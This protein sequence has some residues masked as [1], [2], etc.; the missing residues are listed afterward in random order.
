[1]LLHHSLMQP[2]WKK[3]WLQIGWSWSSWSMTSITLSHCALCVWKMC[4]MCKLCKICKC[5]NCANCAKCANVQTVHFEC[6]PEM[7]VNF[8]QA[9]Q[10]NE[11]QASTIAVQLQ[12]CN[13]EYHWV[14]WCSASL[15]SITIENCNALENI[16]NYEKL[17]KCSWTARQKIIR[18]GAMFLIERM[19]EIV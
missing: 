11:M 18:W 7:Q 3:T 13:G 1:M 5:V 8:L 15:Q 16:I 17:W 2:S 12:Q 19:L 10:F 6:V 4:K 9:A 14:R